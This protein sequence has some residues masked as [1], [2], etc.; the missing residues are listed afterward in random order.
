M[1]ITTSIT[2]LTPH[3]YAHP[4]IAGSIAPGATKTFTLDDINHDDYEA[5]YARASAFGVLIID[6][7]AAVAG[8]QVVTTTAA[9]TDAQAV[10]VD[11]T[12]PFT[13]T[14]EDAA[15]AGDG[16]RLHIIIRTSTAVTA[17]GTLTVSGLANDASQ[18]QIGG[19]TYTLETV[20]TDSADNVLLGANA[21]ATIDNLVLAI[22]AGAGA[23]TNYGTGTVANA[24]VTAVKDTAST[25]IATALVA[26]A[27]GNTISTTDPTDVGG[28]LAWGAVTLLTGDDAGDI[29]IDAA[30]A[31]TVLGGANTTLSD[32]GDV[33]RVVVNGTD[34][35]AIP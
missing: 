17:L 35:E 32:V 20:L 29:L 19:Q 18:V 34:W 7:G 2:N 3:E 33:L 25:M 27:A 30:G 9:L 26:G 10:V 21:E 1:A 8:S 22:T 28:D 4:Q 16:W 11:A 24:S 31:D 6:D 12:A 23:G 15:T 13:I 5:D 14:L